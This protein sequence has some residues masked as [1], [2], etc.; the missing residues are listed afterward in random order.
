MRAYGAIR[1]RKL[2]LPHRTGQ[3][4]LSAAH[5][6]F[7]KAANP[8]AAKIRDSFSYSLDSK[9][10]RN[11]LLLE[12]VGASLRFKCAPKPQELCV[13]ASILL[14]AALSRMS[15]FC[16][17]GLECVPMAHFVVAHFFEAIRR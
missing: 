17:R 10:T 5:T 1:A 9:R 13:A 4:R 3:K 6:S 15:D 11:G 16:Q 2:H 7:S 14:S 12:S 8:R